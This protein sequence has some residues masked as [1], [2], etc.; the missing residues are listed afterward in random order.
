MFAEDYH[1]QKILKRYLIW[2]NG[3][4]DKWSESKKFEHQLQGIYF[5]HTTKVA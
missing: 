1:F 3:H 2:T 4:M 5:E